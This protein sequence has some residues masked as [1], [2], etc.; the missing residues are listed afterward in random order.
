MNVIRYLGTFDRLFGIPVTTSNWNTITSIARVLAPAW[1][2]ESHRRAMLGLV[3]R[4]SGGSR[5]ISITLA[6]PD[7]LHRSPTR[8]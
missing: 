5:P 2:D 8:G 3:L 1:L 7:R 6:C 4:P